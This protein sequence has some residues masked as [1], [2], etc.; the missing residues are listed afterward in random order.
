MV[1]VSSKYNGFHSWREV[2]FEVTFSPMLLLAVLSSCMYYWPVSFQFL[3][4]E[5]KSSYMLNTSALEA[6]PNPVAVIYLILV[7]RNQ[8]VHILRID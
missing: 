8:I 1:Q 5:I 2:L 7:Y 4:E 3:V 6:F